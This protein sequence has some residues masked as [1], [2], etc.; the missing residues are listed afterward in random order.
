MTS[1]LSSPPTITQSQRNFSGK[2]LR[3]RNFKGQDLSGADFSGADIRG[4]NFT[5][6]V[7]REATFTSAKAGVQRRWVFFQWGASLITAII[8]GSLIGYFGYFLAFYFQSSYY[9]RY[10]IFPGLAILFVNAV[11]IYAIARQ[12]LT[13]VA[14]GTIAVTVAVAVAVASTVANTGT[15]AVAVAVA[16]TVAVA[17]SII[18]TVAV[19][20]TVAVTMAIIDTV[21]VAVAV[22]LTLAVAVVGAV[23]GAFSVAGAVVVVGALSVAGAITGAVVGAVVGILI[24]GYVAWCISKDDERFAV[25][26]M[27]GVTFGAVG[28]T[29]FSGADLTNANFFQA[30]LKSSNFSHSK[31]K[32]TILTHTCWKDVQ[33]LER[34]RLGDSILSTS[35]VRKL[36]TSGDGVNKSYVRVNLRNANLNGSN[37]N[38]ANFKWADLSGATLQ[39][40][41]L[42]YANLTESLATGAD[43]SGAYLTGACIES[44]NI[45]RTTK[46]HNVNCEFIFQREREDRQG[47][48]G[49]R[50]HNPD[51]TFEAGDFEKLFKE[52][53]DTVEILIR[54]GVHPEAF[55]IALKAIVQRY[56]EVSLNGIETRQDDALVTLEVP[57]GTDKGKVEQNW[58][59]IYEARLAAATATAQLE[60]EKRRADDIKEITI[61]SLMAN[62]P[63]T[64]VTVEVNTTAESKAMNDSTDKSRNIQVGRDLNLSNAVLNLG[65]LSGTVTNTIQ[66]IPDTDGTANLKDLLTQLQSAVETDTFLNDADKA[67][68]LEQVKVLAEAGQNPQDGALKKAANTATKI[69]KGTIAAL[70]STTALVKAVTDIL[71]IIT[72]FFG[73]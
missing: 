48:R 27:I 35:V 16:V 60:A 56:P 46:L 38:S 70:P 14:A 7:L 33:K 65:E 34:A 23:A 42:Q 45:D 44:W 25:T 58:E 5:N 31:E 55:R 13:T 24:G 71:P 41:D 22:T 68:A 4:A 19:A 67:E 51:K 47:N 64:P 73:L 54:G 26:R 62:R 17:V 66:Q 53:M 63:I 50:P 61:A 43:F 2:N 52:M 3:G 37:L 10:S 6:A 8:S 15:L 36:L 20:V 11:V 49:R 39:G 59:Q 30:V 29:T 21:V 1:A 32:Q 72:K 69:L 9:D 12:G 57:L 18:V 28:G 40:A